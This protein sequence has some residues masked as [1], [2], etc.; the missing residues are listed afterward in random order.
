[1]KERHIQVALAGPFESGVLTHSNCYTEGPL[2]AEDLH[3]AVAVDS[4]FKN[5]A[6]T[7]Y[8]SCWWPLCKQSTYTRQLLCWEP[9]C[10]QST[11]TFQL[12]LRGPSKA[13]KSICALQWLLGA[14]LKVEY[15]HIAAAARALL[16][17]EY[18]HTYALQL[19]L[20]A[21]LRS[22][23][24]QGPLQKQSTYALQWLLGAP[25][26]AEYLRV[27]VATGDLFASSILAQC[28]CC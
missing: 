24:S 15:L 20:W 4:P 7:R 6:L 17:A 21:L 27:A 14:L 19:L 5:K 10:K 2:K 16:K 25:L 9:L 8:T 28:I 13:G 22:V 18:V 1:L 23:Y 26:K 3:I 12:L 11:Y